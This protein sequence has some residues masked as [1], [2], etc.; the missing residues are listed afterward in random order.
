MNPPANRTPLER[1]EH[2]AFAKRLV[3]FMARRNM[4]QSDLARAVWGNFVDARGHDTARSRDRIS[5]YVRGLQMPEPKTAK[6]IAD[7]LGV[8]PVDLIPSLDKPA[9]RGAAPDLAMSVV[10]GRPDTALLT[11]NKM[12]PLELAVKVLA[13]LAQA[14][15]AG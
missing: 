11:V 1:A 10:A 7:A 13:M 12:I 15:G 5:C 8:S 2:E 4:S 14:E 3:E 6:A 9:S